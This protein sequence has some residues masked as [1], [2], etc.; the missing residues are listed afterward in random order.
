MYMFAILGKIVHF[1]KQTIIELMMKQKKILKKKTFSIISSIFIIIGC[2]FSALL[3][4]IAIPYMPVESYA[5]KMLLFCIVFLFLTFILL[6]QL[7]PTIVYKRSA[8][9]NQNERKIVLCLCGLLAVLILFLVTIWCVAPQHLSYS[10][11]FIRSKTKQNIVQNDDTCGAIEESVKYDSNNLK[12]LREAGN[13]Y[14]KAGNYDRAIVF[15]RDAWAEDK[16]NAYSNY[17][18]GRAYLRGHPGENLD[19]EGFEF[20]KYSLSNAEKNLRIAQALDPENTEYNFELGM[21]YYFLYTKQN[22]NEIY[23]NKAV[24]CFDSVMNNSSFDEKYRY[25]FGRLLF[26]REPGRAKDIFEDLTEN[27]KYVA[28]YQFWLGR[29]YLAIDNNIEAANCFE[30]AKNLDT[31]NT[32]YQFYAD[33]TSSF[34]AEDNWHDSDNGRP[35]YTINE[36]NS[37][38][39]KDQ[40]T[41]NSISDSE[42]GDEKKFVT[43]K[44]ASADN[45][46]W[47]NEHINV[48]DG[49]TYT[50][51]LYVNNDNPN[52]Y[53]AIGED[54]TA[55]FRLPTTVSESQTIIGYLDCPNAKPT[56]Y[57]DCVTLYSDEPF[58]IEY[59]D[60]TAQF[61]NGIDQVSIPNEVIIYGGTKLGYETMDGKIPGGSKYSGYVTIDVKVH[62][63]VLSKLSLKARNSDANEWEEPVY[64]QIGDEIIYQIE[65]QNLSSETIDNVMIR[66]ILPT[67][68]EYVEDSTI[69]FNTNYPEGVSLSDNTITTT[70]I[71]IGAYNSKGNAYIRFTG[72]V[73]DKT[74]AEGQNQ[75]VNWASATIRTFDDSTYVYKDDT[76]VMVKK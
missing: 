74:L 15:Y 5:S 65:Y 22:S 18:L 48:E 44:K 60:G 47:E 19:D 68:V 59:L 42:Y 21:T 27:N 73:I 72:R 39:L 4:I 14:Y 41:F 75:L 38:I 40:I 31:N 33:S 34:I 76:S 8:N 45:E 2:V 28:P 37:G 13:T 46:L 10:Y 55:T 69:L 36:I 56:R 67:N 57:L 49:E 71:N 7:L 43:A 66:D 6:V 30:L 29:S 24:D 3:S 26:Y 70:G 50:I 53:D 63:S 11:Y 64:A 17:L 23:Y 54:V 32:D 58:Y 52:G 35:S 25:W 9:C 61:T 20:D 51:R 16:L 62:K 1:V 12:Y